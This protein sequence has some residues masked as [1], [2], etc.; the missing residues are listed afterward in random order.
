MTYLTVISRDVNSSPPRSTD[1]TPAVYRLRS[2][3][4]I[5]QIRPRRQD[6]GGGASE[7]AGSPTG[8]HPGGELSVEKEGKVCTFIGDQENPSQGTTLA[9]LAGTEEVPC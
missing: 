2:Q 8:L 5:R 6:L 3:N 7:C 4:R 9:V 1:S